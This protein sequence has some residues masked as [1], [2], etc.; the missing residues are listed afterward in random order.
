MFPVIFQYKALTI[1][2]F[3]V[4]LGLAFYLAFLL[5]SS[6]SFFLKSYN[7][8]EIKKNHQKPSLPYSEKY[9][10][11]YVYIFMNLQLFRKTR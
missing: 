1:T 9:A 8:S 11:L 7:F 6:L 5:L 2:T 3:G 10:I 4:L